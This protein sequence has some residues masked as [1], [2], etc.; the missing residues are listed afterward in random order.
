MPALTAF[1]YSASKLEKPSKPS[2][3]FFMEADHGFLLMS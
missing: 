2:F 3:D 1:F